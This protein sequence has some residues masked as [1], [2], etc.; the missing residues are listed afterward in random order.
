[1]TAFPVPV[2]VTRNGR[3]RA[4]G[5]WPVHRNDGNAQMTV[6]PPLLRFW[7]EEKK[8]SRTPAPGH[9]SERAQTPTPQQ[10][11]NVR[12]IPDCRHAVVV[13]MM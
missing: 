2:A 7:Q 3:S 8:R 4:Q 1:M 12:H 6:N 10:G 11:G 13:Y 5:P 9:A